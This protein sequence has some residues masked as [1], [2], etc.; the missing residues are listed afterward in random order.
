[1]I[2][3]VA[4]GLLASP[5]QTLVNTVNTVGIMGKGIAKTFK[6]IFPEMF[7]EYQSRCASGELTAGR[8]LLYRTP[9]KWVLNFPTNRH[10]RQP[11]RLE[12]ID[13]GLH[14]FRQSYAEQS[15][16]SVAFPQ[17]G[18]GHGG[19]D[20]EEQVRPLMERHL[21]S[22][23]IDVFVHI[24]GNGANE[25]EGF[26][27]DRLTAWLRGADRTTSFTAVWAELTAAV[28]LG[29]A[30]GWTISEDPGTLRL[31]HA[32]APL[33]LRPD[34]LFDLWRRLR[35]FGYLTP[36]DV[37][38]TLGVPPEPVLGL[39]AELPFVT[40][41]H[42]TTISPTSEYH[43]CSTNVLLDAP[44]ARGVRFVPALL[45]EVAAAPAL[46]HIEDDAACDA[47]Q[48]TEQLALFSTS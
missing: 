22:L 28:R 25:P 4:K 26:D 38:T 19:L 3:Y 48:T 29:S 40:P 47:S 39:L 23:P 2:T 45:G 31:L 41:A 30:A 18:C 5:A 32:S 44:E 37:A 43:A 15:I 11:S 9:H 34:D 46:H 6:T 35:T 16:L 20:W 14:A 10:W 12:D 8:L 13:A 33:A 21:A 7:E 1:L 27:Q 24:S 42:L 17:L 36:E